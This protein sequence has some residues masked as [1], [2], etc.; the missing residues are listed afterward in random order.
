MSPYNIVDL[1]VYTLP[2]AGGIVGI[3]QEVNEVE[4]RALRV[5]SFAILFIYIHIVSRH[6]MMSRFRISKMHHR[7]PFSNILA[8]FYTTDSYSSFE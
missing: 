5:W 1:I 2:L 6:L 8:H 3:V 4:T 7:S